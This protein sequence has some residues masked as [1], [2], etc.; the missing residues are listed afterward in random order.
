MR[1]AKCRP[2]QSEIDSELERWAREEG[3]DSYN[4]LQEQ[5]FDLILNTASDIIIAGRTSGGKT[6][7]AFLPLL[8]RAARRRTGVSVLCLGPTKSLINDQYRRLLPPANRVGVPLYKWHGEAPQSG[9]NRLLRDGLGVV[10]M[11]SESLEGWFLRRHGLL[12]T[13][14]SDLDAIVVD[15]LHEFLE[16]PRGHQLAAL[17]PRIDIMSG[18]RVR[19]IALSATIGDMAFARR[20]ICPQDQRSVKLVQV[21]EER[22]PLRSRI[23]GYDAPPLEKLPSNYAFAHRKVRTAWNEIEGSLFER[24]RVGT[25]LVFARSRS[26]VEKLCSGL[27]L[28]CDR[29][30]VQN[31]FLA[32]HG[33]IGREAR[34]GAEERL[35]NGGQITVICTPTL[36]AG[37]DIGA[38]HSVELIGAPD[39]ITDLRQQVG[40]SGRRENPAAVCIHVTEEPLGS[41]LN[42]MHRLRLQTARACAALNL[43]EKGFIEPP[44][45]DGTVCS[46]LFQQILSVIQ[47][48]N[49]A[50]FSQLLTLAHSVSAFQIFDEKSLRKLLNHLCLPTVGFLEEVPG[51]R[52]ILSDK[53]ERLVQSAEFYAAFLTADQWDVVC[54][55]RKIGWIS[56]ANALSPGDRF[57]LDGTGW[58]VIHTDARHNRLSVMPAAS[59]GIPVFDSRTWEEVHEELASEMR[60]VLEDDHIPLDLD[61][62][63][64]RHLTEGRAAYASSNLKSQIF[65]SDGEDCHLLSWKGGRFNRLL[66]MVLGTKGFVCGTNEV[67][68]S[69]VGAQT[70][71]LRAALATD[72]PSLHDLS[73][74]AAV[75]E[76]KYD[77]HIPEDIRR[78]LWIKRHAPLANDVYAFCNSVGRTG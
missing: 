12:K 10:L 4:A 72:L 58:Q 63:A 55:N 54:S 15:E 78:S 17:L 8:T 22:Q 38:V 23:K 11:T 3:W 68:V 70:D 44:M 6:E 40:R 59:G 67:G 46:V 62:I 31:R 24:L 69:I 16:G 52:L 53:G 57:C 51:G 19:R 13:L 64:A 35:R 50:I 29:A 65:L 37:M 74:Q 34:E 73:R 28:R 56:L 5:S 45:E 7:A 2:D 1:T 43:I 14:F 41:A 71:E 21:A 77:R 61:R 66:G 60:R 48:R 32:H 49:G 33:S 36:Q 9:K 39:S 26:N 75:L 20:W 30:Q 25:H 27:A 76:G 18:K 42:L 47:Q